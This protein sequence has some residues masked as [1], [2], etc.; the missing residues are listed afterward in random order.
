MS[1]RGWLEGWRFLAL[2]AA[3]AVLALG[4]RLAAVAQYEVQHPLAQRPVIDEAS[5][6]RWALEIAAGD[7]VGRGIFFQEPLYPYALG[8]VY[9]LAGNELGEQRTAAR[10]VQAVLGAFATLL[11]IALSAKLFGPAPALVAG[12]AFAT[13]RPAIWFSALL[14][15]PN[16][17]LPILA[18]LA[19]ALVWTRRLERER[20][21]TARATLATWGAVGLLAGL[22]A[23][24]RGNMLVLAPAIVLWPLARALLERRPLRERIPA[25]TA[26]LVGIAIVLAPV[27]L[28]NHAVGGR[29]VLTTSGA[30]TNFYGG[31]NLAN[32]FGIATEFPWVRGIPEHEADDWRH[33]AERRL[34]RGLDPTEVS[35]YWRNEALRSMSEHPLEHLGILWRKL[36]LTLGAYEVP[37]NHFLEW[38]ARYV[39][40]LAL[41]IPGFALWGTLGIA[42]LLYFVWTTSRGRS[43]A[44]EG[45]AALELAALFGLYLATIV[46]TVTSERVRLALVPLLLPFAGWF[47]VAVPA[48]LRTR[49]PAFFASIAAAAALVF[50]PVLPEKK[51]AEDFDERDFNLAVGLVRGGDLARA[52]PL[53]AGL[54][55]KHP[56]SPR[57]LVLS[58]EFDYRHARALVED[59]GS[60]AEARRRASELVQGAMARLERAAS[61]GSAPER[62]RARALAGASW[63]YLGRWNGAEQ[64]YRDA[65][66][67]DPEDRDMRRRLAVVLAEEAMAGPGGEPR[68]LGL[69]EAE[70]ILVDLLREGDDPEIAQLVE[71]IR[72]QR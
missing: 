72:K 53:V 58:A 51:R 33:E 23:L 15:K 4:L 32:P 49:S 5:Y 48:A 59:P 7:W 37:D 69:R 8:I 65:L 54:A 68:A 36:R 46:L 21:P 1:A 18:L 16:L 71:Q 19:L 42:G 28:R 20:G 3:I 30:G 63:Q 55:E 26:A 38:D 67:F 29:L 39:P 11:V 22:G 25:A 40:L 43:P 27:A 41:P 34:E 70:A 66:E 50:V 9:A 24:L 35:G 64:A 14:L 12:L 45:S 31:N 17:F 2:A 60:D 56:T 57:V 61:H 62:F 52:A 44:R 47:V 13:Y 10:R 6:E